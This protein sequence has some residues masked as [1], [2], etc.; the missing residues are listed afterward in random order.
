MKIRTTMQD[1]EGSDERG[2]GAAL[3]CFKRRNYI[4]SFLFY[5]C[6]GS[7]SSSGGAPILN[8]CKIIW[9]LEGK[10]ESFVRNYN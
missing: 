5:H 8:E 4:D 6:H 1:A 3:N 10:F 9:R 7:S 2:N